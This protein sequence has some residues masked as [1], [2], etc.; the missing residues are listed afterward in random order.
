MTRAS[1]GYEPLA[2]IY[3]CPV[4]AE[5]A[6][7][8]EQGEFALPEFVA[9]LVRSRLMRVLRL[10]SADTWKLVNWNSPDDIG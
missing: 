10:R 4:P 2:A 5:A 1:A 7:R 8:L 9:A 3:P 6:L